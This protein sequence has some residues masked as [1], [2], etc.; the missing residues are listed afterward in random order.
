[1]KSEVATSYLPKLL[2][3]IGNTKEIE[4][5]MAFNEI[6]ILP[7]RALQALF[8]IIVLGVLAYAANDWAGNWWNGSHWSPS[9]INFLIFTSVWTLLALLYLIIA[10]I[11]APRYSH[12]Y[13]ILAVEAVTM[14]FWFA[15]FIALSCMVS[16]VC[17]SSGWGPCRASVAGAVF[18]A[19]EWLLF[20]FTTFMAAHHAW[21]T[22]DSHNGKHDPA[23]EVQS[24]NI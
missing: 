14:L 11:H 10:P 5:K 24:T 15:G 22:R 13:G 18:G 16:D 3:E 4:I 1:V 8:A 6:I 12:K 20:S 23:I 9:Q 2:P 21:R 19:F 7:I 17:G